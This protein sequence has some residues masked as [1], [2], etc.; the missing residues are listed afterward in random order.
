MKRIL[1]VSAAVAA[2]A[3]F[4]APSF[5]Q[6]KTSNMFTTG[7]GDNMMVMGGDMAEG[8]RIMRS[9]DY[10]RPADCE[11][12]AY[13]MSGE[14]MISACAE[15]GASFDMAPPAEGQMMQSGEAFPAGSMMLMPR[16]SGEQKTGG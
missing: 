12:G 7:E 3:M 13:Y 14:T 5:A 1:K 15:G 11:D 6:D 2:I 4:A 8:A 9:A 16:E 10:S